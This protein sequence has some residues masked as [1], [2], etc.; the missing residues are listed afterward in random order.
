MKRRRVLVLLADA[1]VRLPPRRGHAARADRRCFGLRRYSGLITCEVI[2]GQTA[3]EL[4]AAFSLRVAN[5]R[6]DYEREVLRPNGSGRLGVTERGTGTVSPGGEVS[7][8][9]S[10]GGQTGSYEASYRGVFDGKSLRL[11]GTQLWRLA[12]RAPHSRPCT[13]T[14]LQTG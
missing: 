5:G 12:N 4:K 1:A 9:G 8:A 11:S 7:L 14:V 3:Q 6:A 13:V 2:P 10:A